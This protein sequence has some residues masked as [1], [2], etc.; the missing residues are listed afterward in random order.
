MLI[1]KNDTYSL[2]QLLSYEDLLLFSVLCDSER[3]IFEFKKAFK[4]LNNNENSSKTD[5]LPQ[6]LYKT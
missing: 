5:L 3:S 2:F 1:A 6:T 4:E